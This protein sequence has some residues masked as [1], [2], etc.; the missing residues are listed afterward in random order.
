M[1]HTAWL[2]AHRGGGH[3][4]W[5]DHGEEDSIDYDRCRS[6]S[7]KPGTARIPHVYHEVVSFILQRKV[8]L[9]EFSH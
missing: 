1:W 9:N 4:L 5:A 8:M 3:Y 2:H 7:R 6:E